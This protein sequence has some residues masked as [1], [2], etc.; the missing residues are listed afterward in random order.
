MSY[1]STASGPATCPR[2]GRLADPT[3]GNASLNAWSGGFHPSSAAMNGSNG[4]ERRSGFLT[5][6]GLGAVE[7]SARPPTVLA[8][9]VVLVGVALAVPIAGVAAQETT[10]ASDE[11]NDPF[12]ATIS[13]FMQASAADAAGTVD[14]GMWAA[15]F[16][17]AEEQARTTM[18][19]AR[20]DALER[21]LERLERERAALLND[22]DGA[23][24]LDER[25]RAARL[26]ARATTLRE[27]AAQTE[28]A[29]TAVGV[30][31]SRLRE[32]RERSGNLTGPAVAAIAV[33]LTDT[34]G[35]GPP[36]DVPGVG[37]GGDGAGSAGGGPPPDAVNRSNRSNN[38]VSDDGPPGGPPDNPPA[39]D[40]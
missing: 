8:A 30:D 23:V 4:A 32:L 13:S 21:R 9:F 29:G 11:S 37:L 2:T 12:G 19:S 18:V 15:G 16:D 34:P 10:P 28:S 3:G 39:N 40:R 35:L 17:R 31:V 1:D 14:N 6:D 36:D 20:T 27:A 7:M 38:S 22:S 26:A 25:A 5:V 24:S 33:N